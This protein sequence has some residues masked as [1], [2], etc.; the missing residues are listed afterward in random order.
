MAE[1][2]YY[3][4][5]DRNVDWGGDVSTGNLP[6]AGSAVQEF[7][8]S[9]LASKVGSIYQDDVSGRYL[10]F[11]HN[12]ARDAYLLDRSKED[13]IIASFIAPSNYKA[14][15]NVD[16]YYNAV[17]INSKENYLTF[18]Y[19]ITHSGEEFVDN[20]RYIISVTKNGKTHTI[21]GTGVYGKSISVNIDEF[22]QLEGTTE[23]SIVITGQT[24]NATASTIITYEV[25]NL[26]FSADADISKEINLN[27]DVIDPFVINYS[28]FGTS[29][30]KYID[31]YIDGKFLETDTI[32]GGTA[33]E[34]ID[35]KRISAIGLSHGVHNVQFRA[36]V[37]VNG[38]NFYTD[39]IYKEFAV[40]SDKTNTDPLITIE[41]IIPKRI[42]ITN[43]VK[44]YDVIQYEPYTLTYAV[45][46]PKHLEYIPVEIYLNDVLQTTV[47]APNNKELTYSFNPSKSGNAVIKFKYDDYY[48]IINA[49]VENTVM[50]LQEIE[51]NLVLNLSASGRTNQ[52]TNKDS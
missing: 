51:N 49:D 21:N 5:I 34:V 12:D 1:N 41:T 44:L 23:I 19:E 37:A 11:A 17:L 32:Q 40:V 43:S 10:C 22:M 45:Y 9:E 8:K 48:K 46:N 50:D 14:K 36:Y 47:N 33:E 52:D 31:W 7:I 38:E 27:S 25:V 4:K 28:I 20:I 30:I 13:L 29:N 6:V 15:I 3:D 26:L 39:T 2:L 18:G 42:D 35:N 16:S 24:T